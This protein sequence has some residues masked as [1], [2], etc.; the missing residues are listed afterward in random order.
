MCVF[1]A[2]A[3]I[4]LLVACSPKDRALAVPPG[5]SPDVGYSECSGQFDLTGTAQLRQVESAEC[6]HTLIIRDA[7]GGVSLPNLVAAAS[8][9]I[10][11]SGPVSL[12]N[13]RRVGTSRIN[14][15]GGL[16]VTVLPGHAASV[17]ADKLE[18]VNSLDLVGALEEA[19]F[20]A[21]KRAT[22]IRIK[23]ANIARISFPQLVRT[24]GFEVWDSRVAEIDLGVLER[25]GTLSADRCPQLVRVGIG[26]LQ[27]VETL[28][29]TADASLR[30]IDVGSLA[31]LQ[32]QVLR[33]TPLSESTMTRLRELSSVP[34]RPRAGRFGVFDGVQ[35]RRVALDWPMRFFVGRKPFLSTV[36][37]GPQDV[38]VRDLVAT[39]ALDRVSSKD[40]VLVA[41]IDGSSR[42]ARDSWLAFVMNAQG[43]L[44]ALHA[45]RAPSARG[46]SPSAPLLTSIEPAGSMSFDEGKEPE[47]FALF[48][49]PRPFVLVRRAHDPDVQLAVISFPPDNGEL[50]VEW[51]GE[52]PEPMT[53]TDDLLVVSF[54]LYAG[55][56]EPPRIYIIEKDHAM[57][58]EGGSRTMID[59]L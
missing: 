49:G 25:V 23:G 26:K 57:K 31:T 42:G 12:P 9:D 17:H 8:I 45:F 37:G 32:K 21:L 5:G 6:V 34:E 54:P 51:D 16:R 11:T 2:P 14:A 10:G 3:A 36:V 43:R 13:L 24:E 4:G 29:L 15:G 40:T 30:E 55:A 59:P 38:L 35:A 39:H 48:A 28:R 46:G 44:R 19:S 27:H 47:D 58:L 53:P 50:T 18:R 1:A 41:P 52:D 20:Q 22:T 33:D 56:P 7:T